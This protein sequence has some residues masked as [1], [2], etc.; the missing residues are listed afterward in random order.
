MVSLFLAKDQEVAGA[1]QLGLYILCLTL[2]LGFFL[3][4]LT[5]NQMRAG[6]NNLTTIIIIAVIGT[7][8]TIY[9]GVFIEAGLAKSTNGYQFLAFGG[10]MGFALISVLARAKSRSIA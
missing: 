1:P 8:L 2:T 4:L 7:A 3:A 5:A 10:F 9:S 6:N